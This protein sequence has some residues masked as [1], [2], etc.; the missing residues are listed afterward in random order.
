METL[1]E[2]EQRKAELIEAR[3][4]HKQEVNALTKEINNVLQKIRY[5]KSTVG[6]EPRGCLFGMFGKKRN[7]LSD[8]EVKEYNNAMQKKRRDKYKIS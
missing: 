2:L 8:D 7:E 4:K 3:D 5:A 1:K 6:K